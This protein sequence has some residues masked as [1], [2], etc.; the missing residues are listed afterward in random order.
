MAL[1][2][3]NLEEMRSVVS[4]PESARIGDYYCV[5]TNNDVYSTFVLVPR[6]VYLKG[7]KKHHEIHSED[8]RQQRTQWSTLE[9]RDEPL[10]MPSQRGMTRGIV[11]TPAY[12]PQL[13][14]PTSVL[15]HLAFYQGHRKIRRS[16]LRT[17]TV[18]NRNIEESDEES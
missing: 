4:S 3:Q 12:T 13:S 11:P 8:S 10:Q 6:P 15:D 7:L 14:H 1:I 17:R 2:S 5:K 16:S 9:T 18:K